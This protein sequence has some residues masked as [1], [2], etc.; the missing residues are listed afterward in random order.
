MKVLAKHNSYQFI[1]KNTTKQNY[2]IYLITTIY[3]I[4]IIFTVNVIFL[5][6]YQNFF[7]M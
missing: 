7:L 1:V 4:E 3:I 6:L 5:Q 2:S